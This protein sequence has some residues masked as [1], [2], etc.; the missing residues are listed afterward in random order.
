M[1]EAKAPAPTI[2]NDELVRKLKT[3]LGT[4]PEPV[5]TRENTAILVIDVQYFDAHPDTGLG[6][7]AKELG[8]M[9]F[10]GYYWDRIERVMLPNIQRILATARRKG[11]EIVHVRVASNTRDGR[12]C[13]LR[14]KAWGA[15]TPVDSKDAQFLPEVWPEG[16]E[17]VINKT[18]ESV[19]NSTNIDRLLRNMGISNVIVVGVVTNGC[20]EG[21]RP[22]RRRAGLRHHPRR[23][24]RRG[25][26][27]PAPR[28]GHRQHGAQGRGHKVHRPGG[29]GAGSPLDTVRALLA[30]QD[31]RLAHHWECYGRARHSSPL[32]QTAL[33]TC[34]QAS[35]NR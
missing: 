12:D 32:S 18:T 28:D 30:F 6:I 15:Q 20:V 10:L 35:P 19:F 22:R 17:I 31:S 21:R 4:V 34:A 16:D 3:L 13:S 29:P 14:F 9:E 1:T 23:G 24:R 8:G 7:R 33:A 5:L 2:S 25:P 11:M 26:G 27:P